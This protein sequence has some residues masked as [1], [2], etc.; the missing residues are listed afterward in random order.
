MNVAHSRWQRCWL[1][2]STADAEGHAP[3][4][5][6]WSRRAGRDSRDA[7]PPR[8]RLQHRPGDGAGQVDGGQ[9]ARPQQQAGV[10]RGLRG[11]GARRGEAC[12]MQAPQEA[13]RPRPGRDGPLLHP[14]RPLVPGADRGRWAHRASL[15]GCHSIT[16]F[17]TSSAPSAECHAHSRALAGRAMFSM[18]CRDCR[19]TRRSVAPPTA[20]GRARTRG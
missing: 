18:T 9:G 15:V 7:R 3:L 1:S 17:A 10:L 12:G 14:R 6:S 2:R 20:S 8:G 13:G 11:P 5:A 19:W 16:I 4:H